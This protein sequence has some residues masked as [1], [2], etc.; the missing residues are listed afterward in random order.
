MNQ[1]RGQQKKKRQRG[2]HLTPSPHKK[3]A[4]VELINAIRSI[5][6][7][8]TETGQNILHAIVEQKFSGPIPHP[9][10]LAGYEKIVPGAA[11]RI[12]QMAESEQKHRHCLENTALQADISEAKRGQ[13]LAFS[14][15]SVVVAIGAYT[16]IN[17]APLGGGLIGGVGVAGLVSAFILGR[18]KKN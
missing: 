11:E 7:L 18:N 13:I 2:N 3:P 5:P 15:G 16:A 6:N 17:G 10:I 12:I 4:D 14:I 9:D 1:R 8:D